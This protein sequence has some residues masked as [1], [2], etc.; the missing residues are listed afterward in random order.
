[1]QFIYFLGRFHLVVLHLPIG[2]LAALV[3]LEWLARKPKYRALQAASPFLW[4]AVALTSALTVALGYMHFAEGGFQGSSADLHRI[5]GT[6]VAVLALGGWVLRSRFHSLYQRAQISLLVAMVLAVTIA[7]HT[8]GSLTHGSTYLVAD[9]PQPVRSLFGLQ[10]PRPPITDV[11][12]ADPYLDIVAP[13]L[14][15]KCSS[16]HGRFDRHGS[17]NLVTLRGI[18]RGGKSGRDVIPGDPL[19]SELFR[20]VTLPHDNKKFMP[21]EDKPPLTDSEVKIM[22]WWIQSGLPT[23]TPVGKM[24]VPASLKPL[25]LAQL[26]LSGNSAASAANG[27]TAQAAHPADPQLLSELYRAGF[28]VRQVSLSNPL[29]I[30]SVP[31]TGGAVTEKDLQALISAESQIVQLDLRRSDI[32]DGDLQAI[33]RLPQLTE[34]HLEGNDVSDRGLRLL[35]GLSKLKYLNLYGN[36]KITD[37]SVATLSQLPALREVYL[38]NTQVTARGAE[39]LRKKRPAL[40]V[41]LGVI[42]ESPGSKTSARKTIAQRKGE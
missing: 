21:P 18:E 34:L 13:M 4:G 36:R 41:N 8:G 15:K 17:L 16:C 9:A 26:G 33:G 22:Q 23:G 7:G 20:R 32:Q 37:S 25:L 24:S 42:P 28:A 40:I 1:M 6:L 2:L 11:A 39:L 30:V 14:D 3:V 10:P 35:A 12:M 31:T 27:E 29:L 38:W 19:H 5:F